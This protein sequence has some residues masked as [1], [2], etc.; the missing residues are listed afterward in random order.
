MSLAETSMSSYLDYI[1]KALAD[2]TVVVTA[3]RRLSRYFLQQFDYDQRHSG[4]AAWPTPRSLSWSEWVESEWRLLAGTD[5]GIG[6]MT[7]LDD[8][9]ELALWE[10]VVARVNERRPEHALLQIPAAAR[11]A[12]DTGRTLS[13]WLIT[14]EEIEAPVS[15]DT[16]EFLRWFSE[17]ERV[18]TSGRWLCQSDLPGLLV[19]LLGEG[20]WLPP[21]PL[22]F[23]GFDEW[24]PVRK[25]LVDRLQATGVPMEILQAP[26]INRCQKIATCK[27]RRSEFEAAANWTRDLLNQGADGPIGI[28]VD[29]LGVERDRVQT[30]FDQVLHQGESLG[31]DDDRKRSFHISIGKP[32]TEYPVVSAALVLLD[33]MAGA[34]PIRDATQLLHSPFISG[35]TREISDHSRLELEL[36]RKG[37]PSVA[38]SDLCHAAQSQGM[39]LSGLGQAFTRAAGYATGNLQAPPAWAA[40]FVEWLEIFG[41]PGERPLNS[42]EYQTVEAW[43]EL[44]SQFA[45]LNVIAA[46]MD[47]ATAVGTVR[48]MASHRIFQAREMPAP[49][50]ILGVAESSGMEFSDL[51]VS[52]MT[53]DSW[54]PQA[55]P[56]P[57]I[58][59][60][61]QRRLGLPG[62]GTEADLDRYA[63]LAARLV[64]SSENVVVSHALTDDDRS[65]RR[66]GLFREIGDTFSAPGY[67]GLVE[68]IRESSPTLET[69]VDS[70]GP[71]LMHRALA[72]GASVF[73]DQSA[74]PF[75]AFARHRLG[76]A[77]A[78]RVEPGLD[79]SERGTLVHDCMARVWREIGSSR[80]LAEMSG[81]D[82]S[83]VLD[84]TIT[85]AMQDSRRR[86]RSP[87][88]NQV[89]ALERARLTGMIRAWLDVERERNPFRVALAEHEV[90]AKYC[91]LEMK[92]RVDRIDE[93]EDGSWLIIDYKTGRTVSP[94]QWQ[95]D[96]PEDPQLP[97]YL[98][99]LELDSHDVGGLAFAHLRTGANRFVGMS[100]VTPFAS[101]VIVPDSWEETR[102]QWTAALSRLADQFRRGD[103]AVDPRDSKVCEYC[104]I[105]PFCRVFD[106][107]ADFHEGDEP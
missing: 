51:W 15:E 49:V 52:G 97:L 29:D 84:R 8:D 40:S 20:V 1:F 70:Q 57:F 88:M 54:P 26:Q 59:F 85:A 38:L 27:D 73:R 46:A 3:N 30:V 9:Q 22:I 43:R 91:G 79:P 65:L 37:S 71:E 95:G 23:A 92:L 53:D 90:P 39:Q 5:P 80:R 98:L 58:P 25:R 99:V 19:K 42:V 101:G 78:P 35:G 34:R 48:R 28:V 62:T 36:R 72:G 14:P 32:L 77:D 93:I 12:R 41:W 18:L 74:C 104:E 6:G 50:Q 24:I 106:H 67:S 61:I 45:R 76:V 2:G 105:G 17:F 94:G 13:D 82:V 64:A 81:D 60:A 56:D 68:R 55:N 4:A 21:G 47:A 103:A 11:A 16:G 7:L 83:A 66:S 10:Q 86:D 63:K 75:R 96:R 69:I 87:F 31:Q 33:F 102:E 89:L 44:L 107:H 100:R